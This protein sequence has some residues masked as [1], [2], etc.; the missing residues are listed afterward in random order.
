MSIT[1]KNYIKM[2]ETY[3][4]NIPTYYDTEFFS[5]QVI[6]FEIKEFEAKTN[7]LPLREV[8]IALTEHRPDARK[9]TEMGVYLDKDKRHVVVAPVNGGEHIRVP[10]IIKKGVIYVKAEDMPEIIDFLNRYPAER[11]F[12]VYTL[13]NTPV[14][15]APPES[16]DLLRKHI[17][18]ED[19]A[20]GEE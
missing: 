20:E 2:L 7:L 14:V 13:D 9:T 19:E 1:W 17:M 12:D 15:V 3:W 8:L 5:A 4:K 16:I 18:G 11:V 6:G 10:V